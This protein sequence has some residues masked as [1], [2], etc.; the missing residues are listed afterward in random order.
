MAGK[1]V[2]RNVLIVTQDA[3]DLEGAWLTAGSANWLVDVDLPRECTAKIRYRQTDQRCRVAACGPQLAVT[4]ETPQR[5]ITPGQY[6]CFYD[7]DI[8]LGGALI[9]TADGLEARRTAAA[10]GR[11]RSG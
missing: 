9:E 8:C 3:R 6:V 1:D 2:A 4:F 5:A 7:G 10:T 11:A